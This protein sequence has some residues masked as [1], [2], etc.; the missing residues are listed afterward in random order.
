MPSIILG[1]EKNKIMKKKKKKLL[2]QWSL[3]FRRGNTQKILCSMLQ[4][5]SKAE[6]G[7]E[8]WDYGEE[9]VWSR[10]TSL[11]SQN[12]G[13][14]QR[15]V[16]MNHVDLSKRIPKREKSGRG[17]LQQNSASYVHG[18]GRSSHAKGR[19]VG[20]RVCRQPDIYEFQ[21][22]LVCKDV[23]FS[24]NDMRRNGR[25]FVVCFLFFLIGKKQINQDRTLVKEARGLCLEDPVGHSFI[26]QRE[27]GS[28]KTTSS[29]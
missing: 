14:Y 22:L 9:A 4:E 20:E 1:L 29:F 27:W 18:I 6:K 25:V 13:H 21:R 28:E 8:D 10:K 16:R 17:A 5:K 19:R 12:W 7:N 3:N 15:E 11:I 24:V 23:S 26:I 2:S